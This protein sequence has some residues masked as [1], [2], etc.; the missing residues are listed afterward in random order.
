MIFFTQPLSYH[1]SSIL[2][3]WNRSRHRVHYLSQCHRLT[4]KSWKRHRLDQ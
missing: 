4:T 2:D 1:K 3:S